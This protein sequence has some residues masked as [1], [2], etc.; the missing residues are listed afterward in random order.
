MEPIKLRVKLKIR[1]VS[2]PVVPSR[3]PLHSLTQPG[4]SPDFTEETNNNPALSARTMEL[5]L[6][7]EKIEILLILSKVDL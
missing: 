3:K 7:I 4:S 2:A 1:N 5:Q 6:N